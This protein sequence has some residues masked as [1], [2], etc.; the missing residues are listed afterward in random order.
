VRSAAAGAA[1]CWG[2]WTS[3]YAAWQ[4]DYEAWRQQYSAWWYSM[5]SA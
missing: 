1:V 3:A 5:H 4:T 2:C